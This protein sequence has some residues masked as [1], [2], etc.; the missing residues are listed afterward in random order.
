MKAYV[1]LKVVAPNEVAR[2]VLTK[3]PGVEEANLVKCEGNAGY[4]AVLK[5]SAETMDELK[6]NM[7]RVR[8][9][10]FVNSSC[11]LIVVN[12]GAKHGQG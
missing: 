11:T 6:E 10:S 9:V 1:L 2:G 4:N 8:R 5:V 12:E 3:L 7:A